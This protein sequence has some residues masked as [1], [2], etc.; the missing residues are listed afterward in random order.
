MRSLKLSSQILLAFCLII[1]LSITD[2]YINYHLSVKVKENT[3]FLNNSETII[4][5]STR[6]HKGIIEMQSAF[7]GYLLTADTNF[8]DNYA[9]GK[10]SVPLLF[11]EQ[12]KIINKSQETDLDTIYALH[13]TWLS[14][15]DSLITAKKY[16]IAN[17]QSPTYQRLFETKLKRMVGK[18]LNDEITARFQVFDRTE[19]QVRSSHGR[20]LLASIERTRMYS[21][22][23]LTLT[24][25]TGIG[26]TIYI[27]TLISRRIGKMVS[28][29]ENISKGEFT[30]VSDNRNDELTRLSTA[31]NVM[32]AKLS[33][34]I[35]E[36][37]KSNQELDKFAYVVSHDLKA[38][39][40]G[41]HNVVNWIE[42]DMGP[43]L[44]PQLREYL[45][46]IPQRTRRMEDLING[47]L[48]YARIREK[49]AP[50]ETDV[51]RL[52]KDI[53][54]DIVPRHFK[55]EIKE[56]P[57]IY[58]E[59]LKL[60]QVFTNLISNAVKYS[61]HNQG[62]IAISGRQ[63]PNCYE[64]SVKDNGIGI[65][66]E[67]HEKIFEIFQTLRERNEEQSTGIGLAIIKKIIDD[68]HCKI[69]VRSAPGDGAEFIFT[70]P[71][72]F[73][74]LK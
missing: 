73:K 7:R 13:R 46:I 1:L 57:V 61:R 43:E 64:F 56:L 59:R 5:N 27:V 71:M 68:Q 69:E 21:F 41:I 16:N 54:Q 11:A 47:L 37:E 10:K 66:P 35:K 15:A 74:V 12:K 14:Y 72:E 67:Y 18:H 39:I 17:A 19:Y 70:W 48:D 25:V 20:K 40:R 38:P 23:F 8:L 58:T 52:V 49:K 4:R 6:L 55:V 36:I 28:L 63:L 53:V 45:R 33:K 42:E 44:S 32:S 62:E 2:S 34:T 24:I 9:A 50:E 26:G 65:E 30:R 29:A 22:I 60:Q 3:E 51:A 31:L